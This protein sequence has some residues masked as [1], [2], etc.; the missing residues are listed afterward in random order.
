MVAYEGLRIPAA[1]QHLHGADPR[2]GGGFLGTARSRF[3]YQIYNPYTRR[4][5]G[6]RYA[7]PFVNNIIP[8]NLQNPVSRMVM[9]YVPKPINDA[10]PTTSTIFQANLIEATD[11]FTWSAA[12]ITPS[13]QN[14]ASSR[15]PTCTTATASAM[16][17][18]RRSYRSATVSFPRA[19]ADDVYTLSRR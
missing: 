12:S 5:E 9:E 16:T 6:S 18:T 2:S 1:W 19:S 11:Y 13:V 15:V 8:A 17:T 4:R 10:R 14:T 3:R 7:G